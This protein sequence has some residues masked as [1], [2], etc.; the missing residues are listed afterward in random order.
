[1][2]VMLTYGTLEGT[3]RDT[4]RSV[5]INGQQHRIKFKYP[6]A[7]LS[8]FRKKHMVDD[9]NNR[10]QSPISF[11]ESWT[12]KIWEYRVFVFL[13]AVT[14]VNVMLATKYFYGNYISSQLAFQK[15]FSKELIF[16]KYV[17]QEVVSG[18]QRSK[19]KSVNC[20]HEL[21]TRTCGKNIC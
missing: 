2:S 4:E 19:R 6:E 11:E 7:F 10:R 14:E 8:H 12:T 1:M 13:V 20:E 9:H 15:K 17:Q 16:N 18:L 3:G 21:L 5:N